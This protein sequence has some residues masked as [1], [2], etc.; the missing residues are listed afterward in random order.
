ML[1]ENLSKY[2]SKIEKTLM[3]NLFWVVEAMMKSC[4]AN[5]SQIALALS[6]L[7]QISFKASDMS[8][9]RLLGNPKFEIGGTLFRCYI[10]LIFALLE[11]R[12]QLKPRDKVYLQVDFTSER[13]HFLIL[14][15]SVLFHGKAIPIYFS[16]RNYPKKE[17]QYDQK[18]MELAFIRALKHNLSNQYRYV[19]LAD[20]GFG[21]DRF[22]KQCQG[23]GFNYIIRLEPN[24]KIKYKNKLGIMS[25]LLQGNGKYE[26]EVISWNKT[27]IVFRNEHEGKIWY[28][29]TTL[30][31][32]E[33][34]EGI[35]H[36]RKRF[37]IE[38]LFQDLKSSGFDIEQTKIRKYMRFKR[39]FFLC[40]L[41]YSLLLLLGEIIETSHPELKK[42]SRAITS[43]FIA[44]SS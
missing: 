30:T 28:I 25:K 7:K 24:L 14:V 27:V 16:I 33:Q 15:A 9:Y 6:Q 13:A 22:M 31:E 21:N 20:R 23:V 41:A 10:K 12:T 19:I 34:P 2:F 32:M 18:K 29:V 35:K 11:E 42:N 36:Y 8:I 39:L 44:Y 26:V 5:T 17:G 1:L 4:S 3:N 37:G 40:C 38:K 43:R